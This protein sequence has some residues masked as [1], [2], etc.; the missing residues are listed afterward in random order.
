M[1]LLNAFSAGMLAGF[2]ANIS[3]E[4]VSAE[5]AVALLGTGFTSGVGHENT[6]AVFHSLL[7]INVPMNRATFSLTGGDEAIIGQYYGQRLPEGATTLPEGATIK[8]LHLRVA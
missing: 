3:F 6:A 8:W 4:E 5:A 7:G 1:Y 2:P